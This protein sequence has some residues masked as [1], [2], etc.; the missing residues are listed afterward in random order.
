MLTK[1]KDTLSMEM[2]KVVYQV[3]CSCGKVYVGETVR[4]LETRMEHRDAC[5]KEGGTGEVS[6]C[7]ACMG[8]PSSNQVGGD[9]SG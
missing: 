9:H 3:P 6:A 8:E 2:S 7:R 5:Q 1:V 4:R